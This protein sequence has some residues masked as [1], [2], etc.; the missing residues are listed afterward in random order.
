MTGPGTIAYDPAVL[1]L[2]PE[3]QHWWFASRTRALEAVL[4]PLA[5]HVAAGWRVLDLGCGAGNMRHHLAPYGEVVGC[6][7][8][9][10]ALAVAVERHCRVLQADAQALPFADQTFDLVAALDVIEHC[11]DD[12]AALGEAYRVLRP[13]GWAVLT[14]PAFSWLWTYNDVINRHYR[15]YTA[16]QLR[17][18]L[19]A[20]GFAVERLSFTNCLIFPVAA[21]RLLLRGER[22]RPPLSAPITDGAYQVEMEPA[23]PLLNAMLEQVGKVEA[24]LVRWAD[25]PVGTGLLALARRPA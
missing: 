16:G 11:P 25:L 19:E 9:R 3:D 22:V 23:P 4:R 20:A 24:T 21:P 2:L 1:S 8:H 12:R 14:V 18:R 6:D 7:P 13:G 5:Q 15:R 10:G 17:A